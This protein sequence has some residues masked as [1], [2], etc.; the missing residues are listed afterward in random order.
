MVDSNYFSVSWSDVDHIFAAVDAAGDEGYDPA[1]SSHP[2][3]EK[4]D[5]PRHSACPVPQNCLD[6]EI[7][8]EGQML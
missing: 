5:Q 2:T 1:T 8:L 4:T 7:S 3:D 6:L